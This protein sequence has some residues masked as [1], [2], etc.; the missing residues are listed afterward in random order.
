MS[1]LAERHNRPIKQGSAVSAAPTDNSHGSAE[2]KTDTRGKK[3]NRVTKDN[4]SSHGENLFPIS[5]V[6]LRLEVTLNGT[7]LKFPG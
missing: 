7:G 4:Q 2:Q 6:L 1:L 3:T 5:L